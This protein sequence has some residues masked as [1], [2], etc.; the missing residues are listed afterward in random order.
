MKENKIKKYKTFISIF[1]ALFVA[2][3]LKLEF[4]RETNF[5]GYT[6]RANDMIYLIFI[7]GISI[8]LYYNLK[9]RNKRLWI[10]AICVGIIFSICYYLGDIQNTY[11]Y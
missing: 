3:G 10:V 2:L 9:N 1:F 5:M 8:L 6:S 7:I 4:N 11:M